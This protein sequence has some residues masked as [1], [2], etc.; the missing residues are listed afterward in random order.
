MTYYGTKELAA[1]FRTVRSNT[2]IAAEEIPESQYGFKATPETRTI[3]KLFVHIAIGY[4]FQYQFHALEK[5]NDFKGFDFMALMT[6]LK[7]DEAKSHT[8]ADV[9]ALLKETEQTWATFVEGLS[10]DFLS[11]M[12]T[13]M[14][15]G[16]P[17]KSKFEMVLS[18]KEHEMH[19]RGQIMLIE[20]MIGIVPHLTRAGQA[21]MAQMQAADNS[22]S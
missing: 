15:N 12:V 9:I 16:G 8:K 20:R 2:I 4:R 19:H 3:E 10:E 22:K 18:V 6:Q 17:P 13:M 7:A 14:P 5:R 11:Q 1:S 21:R